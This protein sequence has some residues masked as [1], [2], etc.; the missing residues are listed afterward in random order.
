MTQVIEINGTIT[1]GYN[2]VGLR[3]NMTVT[4]HNTVFYGYDNA[5][6]LTNVTQG[7]FTTSLFD[8][9]NGRNQTDSPQRHQRPL[10]PRHGFTA[11]EDDATGLYYYRLRYFHPTL[12]RFVSEDPLDMVDGPDVYPYVANAPVG[13]V[14]PMG[15]KSCRC[16]FGETITQGIGVGWS[17]KTANDLHSL[18]SDEAMRVAPLLPGGTLGL[19]NGAA[20]AFRHCYWSCLM[21][22]QIGPAKAK[23]VGD[24]HEACEKRNPPDEEAMDQFNNSFGRQLGVRGLNCH[25]QCFWAASTGWTQN[26]PSGSPPSGTWGY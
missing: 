19:H 23:I 15:L 2:D 12:G 25:D 14:D 18:A 20:D 9:D 26:S 17:A 4:G 11:R 22:E 1:Y 8:D 13:R 24:I 21:A 7:T 3:T 16:T 5:N 10:Q 6:W